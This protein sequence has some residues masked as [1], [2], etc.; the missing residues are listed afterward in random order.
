MIWSTIVR[1]PLSSVVCSYYKILRLLQRTVGCIRDKDTIWV[2]INFQYS[3]DIFSSHHFV[4]SGNFLVCSGHLL[5][6]RFQTT[7]FCFK[8]SV[9]LKHSRY[10]IQA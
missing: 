1:Q 6:L 5:V 7:L 9:A 2:M 8:L 10:K 3:V 4:G